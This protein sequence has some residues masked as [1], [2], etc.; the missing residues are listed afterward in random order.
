M[1][2]RAG[3]SRRRALTLARFSLLAALVGGCRLP[4][5]ALDGPLAV[6][7]RIDA[8]ADAVQVDAPSW[9]APETVI[10]LC[11]TEP[12]EL[13]EPGPDRV[14]WTPGASC[15]DYGKVAAPNGLNS[16]VK[17]ETSGAL[18]DKLVAVL[19]AQHAR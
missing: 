18:E 4:S 8:T 14:G 7:L 9:F 19:R 1:D 3:R 12:P 13:P 11:S 10:Y 5:S 6:P 15:H 16:S 2:E 17:C